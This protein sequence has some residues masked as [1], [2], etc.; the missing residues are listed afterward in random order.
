[1]AENPPELGPALT[2]PWI[3]SFTGTP[4]ATEFRNFDPSTDA[5][6]ETADGP[7]A[8]TTNKVK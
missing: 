3:S 8:E 5:D 1:L 7:A 4:Q 2:P 6:G